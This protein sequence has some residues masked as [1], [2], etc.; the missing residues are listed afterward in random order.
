MALAGT[1]APDLVIIVGADPAHLAEALTDNQPAGVGAIPVRVVAAKPGFL[2]GIDAKSS[3]AHEEISRRLART[4][5][6]WRS[7]AP[8]RPT[9]TS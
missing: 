3:P 2:A 6:K 7:L 8:R 1:H 9:A 4:P 5:L